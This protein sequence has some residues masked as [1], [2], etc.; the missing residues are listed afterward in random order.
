MCTFFT[1]PPFPLFF[2]VFRQASLNEAAEKQ[3]ERAASLRPDVSTWTGGPVSTSCGNAHTHVCTINSI[4]N[5]L[6]ITHHS[7]IMLY[8]CC[9]WQTVIQL[10]IKWKLYIVHSC[11]L[12][13]RTCA[14]TKIPKR[15]WVQWAL[16]SDLE[17]THWASEYVLDHHSTVKQTEPYGISC[18]WMSAHVAEEVGG[19]IISC[20]CLIWI[21]HLKGK[22]CVDRS[23]SGNLES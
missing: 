8:C 23:G 12:V 14:N 9:S 3:Y 18:L 10:N 6:C 16:S 11:E 5:M 20:F 22:V 2:F 21:S 19:D 4:Y 15:E 13:P 17:F 1:L 7:D